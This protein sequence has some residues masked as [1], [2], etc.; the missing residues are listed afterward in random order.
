[1]S[2]RGTGLCYRE[3]LLPRRLFKNL[4]YSNYQDNEDTEVTNKDIKEMLKKDKDIN[5]KS[6]ILYSICFVHKLLISLSIRSEAFLLFISIMNSFLL[7][8]KDCSHLF[9]Q[10]SNIKVYFKSSLDTHDFKEKY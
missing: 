3:A 8:V 1:M 7:K 4:I 2:K 6:N 10:P 9:S 5:S